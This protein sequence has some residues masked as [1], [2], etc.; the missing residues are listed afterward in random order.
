MRADNEKHRKN[1]PRPWV[2]SVDRGGG[3]GGS[4]EPPVLQRYSRCDSAHRSW[5]AFFQL[6]S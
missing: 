1:T 5:E 4:I 6:F 3:G 2:V